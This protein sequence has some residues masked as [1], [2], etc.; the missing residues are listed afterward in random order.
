LAAALALLTACQ[1]HLTNANLA[2]VKPGMTSKEV[3]SLLGLPAKVEFEGSGHSPSFTHYIYEQDGR[4]VK[5]T[6]TEDRLTP[7]GVSGS[8]EEK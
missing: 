2:E 7:N 3:E 1:P 6:F 4:K 8:F 5:L